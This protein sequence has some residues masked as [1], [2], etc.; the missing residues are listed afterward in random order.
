MLCSCEP[1]RPADVSVDCP[2]GRYVHTTQF[3]AIFCGVILA[4][5]VVKLGSSLFVEVLV[6]CLK[7]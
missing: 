1:L 5:T 6:P 7:S 4:N 2:A 3:D